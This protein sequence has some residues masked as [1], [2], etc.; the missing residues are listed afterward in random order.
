[1][2]SAPD[3]A[4]RSPD[5]RSTRARIRDAAIACFAEHGI[6]GTTVR[7]VAS[8]AGVSPGSVIHHFDSMD[9]LRQACDEHVLA[10][11]RN[12]KEQ[13]ISA[14]PQLDLMAAL[15]EA[16]TEFAPMIAYLARVLADDS[17]AVTALVDRLVADAEHLLAQGVETGMVRPA[18]DTRGRAVVLT[19]WSLGALVLHRHLERLLGADL[20]AAR[21]DDAGGLTAYARPAYELLGE[22]MF[23]EA[24]ARTMRDAFATWTGDDDDR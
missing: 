20:L 23:T 13:S 9:G 4:A 3:L 16:E 17:P 6:A 11:L 18:D 12:R 5:D 14:G 2:S 21:P 8:R 7:K 10:L 22:G 1:M 15:R 19:I 24:F